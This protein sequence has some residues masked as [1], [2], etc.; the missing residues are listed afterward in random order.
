VNRSRTACS[1]PRFVR[2]R[3]IGRSRWDGGLRPQPGLGEDRTPVK[4][5]DFIRWRRSADTASMPFSLQLRPTTSLPIVPVP[6][7]TA[8]RHAHSLINGYYMSTNRGMAIGW[9]N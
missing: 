1:P 4:E 9:G 8:M 5:V 2:R 3:G 7:A 6:Q